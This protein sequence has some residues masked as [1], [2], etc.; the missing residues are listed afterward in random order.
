MIEIKCR[1]NGQ[2]SPYGDYYREFTVK[3]TEGES[4][5]D[6]L[7]YIKRGEI[8]CRPEKETWEKKLREGGEEADMRDYFRGYYTLTQ[9]GKNE[10]LYTTVEPYTD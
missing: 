2:K 7:V 9:I 1:Y 4:R 8:T 3:T 6:I 10:W 5:N